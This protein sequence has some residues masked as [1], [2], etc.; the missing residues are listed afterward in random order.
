MLIERRFKLVAWGL[1]TMPLLIFEMLS[2]VSEELYGSSSGFDGNNPFERG[3]ADAMAAYREL[4]TLRHSTVPDYPKWF[5]LEQC[6]LNAVE[7][8]TSFKEDDKEILATLNNFV[9]P[10]TESQKVL[11]LKWGLEFIEE[12]DRDFAQQSK[13]DSESDP[14]AERRAREMIEQ[15]EQKLDAESRVDL[16]AAIE[17]DDQLSQILRS[18]S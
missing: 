13:D 12:C 2:N 10:L 11:A 8:F 17:A 7:A 4:E 18:R 1:P 6:L 5:W 9:V 14:E 16:A 3:S 15:I